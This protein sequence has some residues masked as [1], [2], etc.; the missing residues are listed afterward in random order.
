MSRPR[1]SDRGKVLDAERRTNYALR[2]GNFGY[3]ATRNIDKQQ[4]LQQ[5]DRMV[6]SAIWAALG[7]SPGMLPLTGHVTINGCDGS[8]TSHGSSC[9]GR[10]QIRVA[11][12]KLGI[13][14]ALAH[15]IGDTAQDEP[16]H[17]P[18]FVHAFLKLS[19]LLDPGTS[20]ELR[21]QL[22]A[23]GVCLTRARKKPPVNVNAATEILARRREQRAEAQRLENEKKAAAAQRRADKKKLLAEKAEALPD[24]LLALVKRMRGE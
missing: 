22:S 24:N 7:G 12:G 23:G 5:A 14:H 1:D 11:A 20:A 21:R 10:I 16:K 19:M 9:S 8:Y 6:H 3:A 17:G 15:I 18:T 4:L 13:A 2:T